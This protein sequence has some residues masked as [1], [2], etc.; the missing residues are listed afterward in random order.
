MDFLKKH[1]EKV[2]LGVVLLGLVAAVG[3]LWFMID[4]EK[5]WITEQREI[6]TPRVKELPA[7]DL[8]R[9]SNALKRAET[10]VELSL[11]GSHNVVSPVTWI[12]KDGQLSRME[13]GGAFGP[14]AVKVLK[15]QPLYLVLSF[16]GT[17]AI[18]YVIAVERQAAPRIG[19]RVREVSVALNEKKELFTLR[20]VKGPP[21]APTELVL[22]MADGG[23]RVSLKPPAPYKEVGGYSA[24]LRYEPDNR[25]F[26]DCRRDS[27][28]I[29]IGGEEYYVLPI[30]ET[31]VVLSSK[32]N[33]KKTT[34]RLESGSPA[35]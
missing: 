20:E 4:S 10:K 22:E 15:I 27:K 28:P 30:N 8:S 9:E 6:N 35:R 5:T 13:A 18:G 24:N 34:I 32:L 14:A 31:D 12:E 16:K 25:T 21:E 23:Q 29:N 11:G 2:V 19:D 3:W 33:G 26:L 7:L 17:N 1:Y